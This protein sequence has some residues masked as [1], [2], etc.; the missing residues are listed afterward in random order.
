MSEKE[1]V[2]LVSSQVDPAGTLIHNELLKLL[3]NNLD[4][5]QRFDHHRFDVR[6]VELKPEDISLFCKRKDVIY[7]DLLFLSRHS[8][9]EHRS[10]LSVHVSGNFGQ[11]DL[12]GQAGHLTPASKYMHAILNNMKKYAP[13]GY[14]V[15]YE[16]T[17]HGPTDLSI[18]SCFVE[19]GSSEKEW[20]DVTAARAVAM[21]VINA[22]P[23]SDII[24]LAGFGGTHYAQR[25]TEISLKTRGA[26]GHMIP[27]RDLKCLN[28]ALFND[29]VVMSQAQGIYIDHKALKKGEI[30]LI[31]E[32]AEQYEIPTLGMTD[33]LIPECMSFDN[34][35]MV[36]S[37]AEKI[38]S[39]GTLSIHG[40][41]VGDN[42]IIIPFSSDLLEETLKINQKK[43][44]REVQNISVASIAAGGIACLPVFIADHENAAKTY[45][46]LIY[47]CVSILTETGHYTRDG[48]YLIIHKKQFDP[49]AAEAV[50]IAKGPAF[51]ELIAGNSVIVDG[52]EI[53]PEMVMKVIE[54]KIQIQSMEHT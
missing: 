25:E 42:L 34:Y 24:R 27:T 38:K 40:N 8:S 18:P 15:T 26:F 31:K 20:N 5:A 23:R 43:F 54:K 36:R 39:G 49:V 3:Q 4:L 11:N 28:T 22:H 7:K 10:V 51:G 46:D 41:M 9:N 2:L 33:L 12:G 13:L 21:S 19:L 50:G 44:F 35:L 17:H 48:D 37:F 14:E 45:E 16:V 32:L 53:K 29:I 1:K 47:L 6:L 30:D 52:R